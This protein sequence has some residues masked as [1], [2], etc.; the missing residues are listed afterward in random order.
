MATSGVP[1]ILLANATAT[2]LGPRSRC[3]VNFGDGEVGQACTTFYIDVSTTG[4]PT[5]SVTI[6]GGINEQGTPVAIGT[7]ITA[8]GITRVVLAASPW[9]PIYWQA[10]LTAISGGGTVR[11][12]GVSAS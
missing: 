10:N 2:G 5:F 1:A 9:A 6:Q 11:V 3:G 8:V 7:A 4:T 12:V